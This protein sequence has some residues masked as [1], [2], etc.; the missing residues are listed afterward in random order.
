MDVSVRPNFHP[1]ESVVDMYTWRVEWVSIT[2]I[3]LGIGIEVD[4]GMYADTDVQSM[5]Q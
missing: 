5:I 4:V 1:S 3:N 2:T